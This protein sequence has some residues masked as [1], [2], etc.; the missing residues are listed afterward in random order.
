MIALQNVT[1]SRHGKTLLQDCSCT[2][3]PGSLSVI[4]GAG[5]A[6]K[7]IIVDLL[8]GLIFPEKGSVTFDGASSASMPQEILTLLRRKVSVIDQVP[9]LLP[10][11]TVAENIALPQSIA[12]AKKDLIIERTHA[13]LAALNMDALAS[14]MPAALS[15]SERMMATIA[16]A[17]AP[18]PIVLIADD[19][20]ALLDPAQRSR[21]ANALLQLH[22]EG[23]TIIVLTDHPTVADVLGGR[24]LIMQERKITEVQEDVQAEVP[25]ETDVESA[26]VATASLPD[27]PQPIAQ[28]PERLSSAPPLRKIKITAI[29]SR[30]EERKTNSKE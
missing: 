21:A 9:Q 26:T 10:Y 23:S 18:H 2:F 8:T 20:F 13:A 6:G 19:P 17:V 4:V 16:R 25:A 14:A 3:E 30:E 1:V 29:A 15:G 7:S 22:G 27:F 12:D 28:D 5:G 24:L 11:L